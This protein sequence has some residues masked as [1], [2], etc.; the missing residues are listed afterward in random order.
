MSK[1]IEMTLYD[2]LTLPYRTIRRY[3]YHRFKKDYVEK[4][5]KVRKGTCEQH[6]CCYNV[7]STR[8]FSIVC[9][10]EKDKTKCSLWHR[11]P[12]ACKIYPFDERDKAPSTRKYCS[13]H[14]EH[15]KESIA[16]I[17]LTILLGVVV[18]TIFVLLLPLVIPYAYIV[19]LRKARQSK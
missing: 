2:T 11:L 6:G 10:D 4:Q 8:L 7:W 18:G 13:F 16:E 12:H 15:Q 9:R 14:W 19:Y 1:A 3:Y 5:I 17:T